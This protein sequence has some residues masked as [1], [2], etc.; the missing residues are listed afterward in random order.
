MR[1]S[2]EDLALL[3]QTSQAAKESRIPRSSAR[4]HGPQRQEK[5]RRKDDKTSPKRSPT[6]EQTESS[7]SHTLQYDTSRETSSDLAAT[8][9]SLLYDLSLESDRLLQ[10]LGP[11]GIRKLSSKLVK[12]QRKID[13][14]REQHRKREEE[15]KKDIKKASSKRK[16]QQDEVPISSTPAIEDSLSSELSSAI[17]DVSDDYH[18]LGKQASLEPSLSPVPEASI[19]SNEDSI[20]DTAESSPP[21]VPIVDKKAAKRGKAKSSSQTTKRTRDITHKDDFGVTYNESLSDAGSDTSVPCACMPR[22]SHSIHGITKRIREKAA[23]KMSKETKMEVESDEVFKKPSA[24]LSKIPVKDS[25]SRSRK[26][27]VNG[28]PVEERPQKVKPGMAFI[29]DV[30]RNNG[31]KGAKDNNVLTRRQNYSNK[32]VEDKGVERRRRKSE[33]RREKKVGQE[34]DAKENEAPSR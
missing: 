11:D 32:D 27:T 6:E 2:P 30:G 18:H 14:Q 31:N 26:D 21:D 12:L 9:E 19:R 28:Q 33:D 34:L 25:T 1:V 13:R 24:A 4:Q 10:M 7:S 17:E 20:Y 23:D 15:Q 8:Q 29:I 16:G 3:V 22:R 5:K